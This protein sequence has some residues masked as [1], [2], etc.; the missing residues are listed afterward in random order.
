MVHEKIKHDDLKHRRYFYKET[1]IRAS[2]LTEKE[3]DKT[4]TRPETFELDMC[5]GDIKR[6]EVWFKKHSV[7][8]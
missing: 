7:M 2:E 1:L 4:I 3:K 8:V 6:C 5:R